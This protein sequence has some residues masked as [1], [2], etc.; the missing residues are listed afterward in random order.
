MRSARIVSTSASPGPTHQFAR[1][2]GRTAP[3]R[4][5]RQE[6]DRLRVCL[7]AVQWPDPALGPKQ[8]CRTLGTAASI[9]GV[10]VLAALACLASAGPRCLREWEYR[11]MEAGELQD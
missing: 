11:G 9:V 5:A 7:R 10:L 2:A 6:T 8:A 1:P 3:S 4:I